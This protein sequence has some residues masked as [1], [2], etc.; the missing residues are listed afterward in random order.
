MRFLLD[1]GA[2]PKLANKDGVTAL[3]VAAGVGYAE[4][5]VRGT[6]AQ[7]LEAVKLC[8]ELGLD[9]K[10]ATDKGETA[11]HG[12]ALRGG[13]SIV[14]FLVEKGVDVN[15]KNKQGVTP[16]DI[17]MGKGGP[18]G[19]IRNAHESTATLIRGLG[20]IPGA[21][22]KVAAQARTKLRMSGINPHR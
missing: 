18:P 22:I 16:M 2:D 1:H 3:L 9:P 7:A 13:D 5:K 10:A 6:E 19:V 12:A 21:E 20:G 4:N 15:A 14:K 8:A 11:L 17:S